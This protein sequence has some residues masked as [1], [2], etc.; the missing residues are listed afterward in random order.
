MNG[1]DDERPTKLPRTSSSDAKELTFVEFYCGVGGW[2]MALE[3]AIQRLDP[4]TQNKLSLRCL[5]ALD[6]SDLCTKVYQYNHCHQN[7][8]SNNAKPTTTSIEKLTLKQVH[9]WNAAIWAMSPP[10]QPHTRQHDNQKADLEDPR[11]KSFLHLCHLMETMNAD[12]LPQ[13]IL[14]ENVVG[15]ETS[16]SCLRMRR[17]LSQRDYSVG[18]FHLSPTQCGIPND[19]PRYYC[20]AVR[21]PTTTATSDKQSLLQQYLQLEKLSFDSEQQQPKESSVLPNASKDDAT[22][23]CTI[24][25]HLE[26]LGIQKT[27]ANTEPTVLP[28]IATILD[29]QEHQ[30]LDLRIPQKILHSKSAWCF[31]IVTPRAQ[32]SACF[33]HGYGKFVRGTGSVL[34]FGSNNND[35]DNKN[36]NPFQLVAPDQREFDADWAKGL[37]LDNTLRYFSGTEMARLLGFRNDFAFPKDTSVKQQWKLMGNSLNVRVAARLCELGLRLALHITELK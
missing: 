12:K 29:E 5:A 30:N 14:V 11:S 15:F 26:E 3:E 13:L 28:T 37:D 7:T 35:N 27:E 21:M 9:K 33:T 18:H 16:Q 10:C 19:R 20:V 2:S 31:D 22:T 6:H 36:N 32:R 1:Q 23:S 8:N 34:Y 17:V 4:D 24:H 25:S